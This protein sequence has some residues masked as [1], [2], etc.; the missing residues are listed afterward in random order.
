MGQVPSLFKVK[1]IVLIKHLKCTYKSRIFLWHFFLFAVSKMYQTVTPLYRIEPNRE[2]CE[3]YTPSSY[4]LWYYSIYKI[5]NLLKSLSYIIR[6]VRCESDNLKLSTL[7]PNLFVVKFCTVW[8][9]KNHHMTSS[10]QLLMTSI[11]L[12][13]LSLIV[14][15]VTIITVD[16]KKRKWLIISI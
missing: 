5:S 10:F 9:L 2:F 6:C 12:L 7:L 3:R 4:T 15:P 16:L 8:L 13:F 11:C 14:N 1:K